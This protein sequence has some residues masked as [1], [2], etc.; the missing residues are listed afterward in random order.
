MD[1]RIIG[2]KIAEK[3]VELNISQ[4]DLAEK[5]DSSA[6]YISNIERGKRNASLTI[7]LKIANELNLSF[8]YL[9]SEELKNQNFRE[10][11]YLNELLNMIQNLNSKDKEEFLIY[12]KSF[13]QTFNKI[14]NKK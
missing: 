13:A 5:I 4:E 8:D 7:L 1:Y 3:R 2:R 10:K 11:A 6:N 9:L 14:K 12:I